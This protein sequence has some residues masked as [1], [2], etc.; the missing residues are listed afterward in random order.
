MA[1]SRIF[2]ITREKIEDREDYIDSGIYDPALYSHF[3]DYIDNVK[4]EQ[5]SL[6][7]LDEKFEGLFVRD[8]RE[9]TLL[10]ISEF[11]EEYKAAIVKATENLDMRDFMT[12]YNLR[13]VMKYT[14]RN[15]DFY[16]NEEI[17]NTTPF[18]FG[19]FVQDIY[20]N[21]KPGDKFYIGGILDYHF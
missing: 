9:L 12:C 21:Y 3:A 8:G 2:Q 7:W 1:H 15:C 11:M 4:D 18:S 17:Y 13:R 19:A 10:D 6:R 20:Q 5:D 14:H 16:I